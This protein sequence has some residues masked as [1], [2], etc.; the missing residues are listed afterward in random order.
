MALPLLP[1]LMGGETVANISQ[2]PLNLQNLGKRKSMG[3]GEGDVNPE[4]D[5]IDREVWQEEPEPKREKTFT[6]YTDRGEQQVPPD[7]SQSNGTTGLLVFQ[8]QPGHNMFTNPTDWYLKLRLTFDERGGLHPLFSRARAAVHRV[9]AGP[10]PGTRHVQPCNNPG[11]F[12]FEYC[13]VLFNN[14][15]DANHT[16]ETYRA[17]QFLTWAM[18]TTVEEKN[19]FE[20]RYRRFEHSDLCGQRRHQIGFARQAANGELELVVDMPKNCHAAR[21]VEEAFSELIHDNANGN[22]GVDVIVGP[23]YGPFFRINRRFPGSFTPK[24]EV[25]L[26]IE[27]DAQMQK[28]LLCQESSVVANNLLANIR[29]T[30]L[31]NRPRVRVDLNKTKLIIPWVAFA[32][33]VA[34]LNEQAIISHERKPY[35]TDK[36]I[37][38][39]S[40]NTFTTQ[41]NDLAEGIDLDPLT[42]LNNQIPDQL[43]IGFMTDDTFRNN[44]QSYNSQKMGFYRHG[45]TRFQIFVGD[46]MVFE[47]GPLDWRDTPS[48][49]YKLW[50]MQCDYYGKPGNPERKNHFCQD[51]EDMPHGGKW[52]WV[53]MNPNSDGGKETIERIDRQITI[54]YWADA[55]VQN[56]RCLI[57]IPQAVNFVCNDLVSNDWVGPEFPITPAYPDETP[58]A[59][60]S[61]GGRQW[62]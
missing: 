60:N 45:I 25:K 41:N 52:V 24:I 10:V 32:D 22:H 7:R 26:R 16:D 30:P 14:T 43:A 44:N 36:L 23:L 8:P 56:L 47:E 1:S 6:T 9:Q 17:R 39:W 48:N 58:K 11:T 12:M 4:T 33:D 3:I 59:F 40:S 61:R 31:N 27:N 51:P 54:R 15:H 29:I 28:W 50:Q 55:V 20:S 38:I 34:L 2:G 49:N 46:R 13:K 19:S 53:T 35:A 5:M 62:T 37:R 42:A 57:F 21:E 18:D